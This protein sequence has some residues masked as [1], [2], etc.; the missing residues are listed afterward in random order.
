MTKFVTEHELKNNK[1]FPE[2]SPRL[3]L[4]KLE[5]EIL[6][7]WEDNNTFQRRV[8]LNEKSSKVY[9]FI[10][11][12]IT[13]NNPMGLHHVWGRSLKDLIQRYWSMK[14][15]KQ[16]FQNGF[17][18]Q[19]LWI[20][21]EVEKSL[22]L[23]SKK[24]IE[25]FGLEE[26][27]N[28]CKM[29]LE[30]YSNLIT[31]Q[32][33][34]LGQWMHWD[35][36]YYTHS[37]TNISYI[38]YF[39]KKCYEKGWLIKGNLPMPWCVRCGTSLS[40][41]EQHD[42]YKEVTHT[43]VYL[44]FEL[45]TESNKGTNEYLL[46]WTTTPWTLTANT[47]V[48]VNPT[49]M[50]SKVKQN[51]ETYYL[52][53][54]LLSILTDEYEQLEVVLGKE[55][56]NRKVKSPFSD[57]S[58]QKG[59]NHR[60]IEWLEVSSEEGTGF[61]HIAPGCGLEDH[62]LSKKFDLAVLSP[63][64]DF[65][66]FSA[67][68]DYFNELSVS[69]AS[70]K[71][72]EL[73]KE[74]NLLY[75]TEQ[76][77][78]R[79][80]TCWRCHEELVFRLVSEW[81]I[82][83]EEIRP[84]LKAAVKKVKW[85][86]KFYEKRMQDWLTNM[87]NWCISRKRYWGLPLPF[88]ECKKC[89]EL[90]IIGSK[91]E[92]LERA[93][94][95]TENLTELHR[96]WIDEVKIKCTKCSEKVSRITEVGD[97]WLDAGIVPFSTLQYLEDKDYWKTWYPIKAVCEMREQIRLWFYSLLFMSVTLEGKAPYKQVIVHE[98]VHDKEGRPMHRS[99]GNA[100][101][102]SEAVEKMGADVMRWAFAKQPLTHVMNFGY[103]TENE[104]KPFFM[105]IWNVY[106]FFATSA[107]LDEFVP[108]K[109][110][111]NKPRTLLD[112]WLLS[113]LN[114]LVMSV[115]KYLDKALFHKATEELEQFV[116]LL[117][118]WYIRRSRRRFWKEE[119]SLDKLS[120][121]NTL[122]TTLVTLCKLLGPIVPFFSD[123]L[124]QNLTKNVAKD[125]PESVHLCDYPKVRKTLVDNELNSEMDIVLEVVRLGRSA[126]NQSKVKLRQPLS[127]L[128]IWCRNQSTSQILKKFKNELLAELN[129]K[130]LRFIKNPEKY[131][132]LSLK[133]NYQI[134]GPHLKTKVQVVNELLQQL[135][136]K[137]IMNAYYNENQLLELQLPDEK[138]KIAFVLNQDLI[139]QAKPI[140][141]HSVAVSNDFAVALDTQLT[142]E[143]QLEGLA[144]DFVRIVQAQR[145][146][147]KFQVNDKI[148]IYYWTDK[149]LVNA[150]ER[151]NDYIKAETLASKLSLKSK[152]D[153]MVEL[154]M[155]QQK[156]YLTI[157]RTK[158]K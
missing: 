134:L 99:W 140:G 75:K 64:D 100:I 107:N 121:Y 35:N 155:G 93:V 119:H 22:G 102:F 69:D 111:T 21:V 144:R 80:P 108:K 15:F 104:V 88:F 137:E 71:A 40:Q 101:W 29:R 9:S 78:H 90:I 11:G 43:A 127:E 18:C 114:Q 59:V 32:S 47:A 84:Q 124:Y 57:L 4:L 154:K 44:K 92:L 17:D 56:L 115:R 5:E 50:Y 136:Q 73:L 77:K 94:E 28:K 2:V 86:P 125:F 30:K 49:L 38:W 106:S 65:G 133:P 130:K 141:E 74:R 12:P 138:E 70:L 27:S 81:F 139:L 58:A 98:K 53:E 66:V 120:A 41:H 8:E 109:N 52:A 85:E 24:S 157:K 112:K 110:N 51:N 91:D 142:D 26:F 19:G 62:E 135:N 54:N 153:D 25:E 149:L 83:C 60:T 117:S 72:I 14:G 123:A 42:A 95:G 33:L 105:T 48:A 13:A 46:V 147:E 20:E 132:D 126:R 113:K 36:S 67:D 156:F 10:D 131:L 150:I 7:Y 152:K 146:K 158:D 6:Q 143:L 61:V 31:Q 87:G 97:C 16:R 63:I 1:V 23:D 68:F 151:F 103:K 3:N 76:Y 145:K 122:F 45:L 89:N 79:Y 55:L 96:P 118:T 82:D 39:L 148:V 34:R 129:V 37:D 128:L 116:E